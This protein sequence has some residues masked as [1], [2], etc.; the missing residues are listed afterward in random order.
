[1]L[2]GDILQFKSTKHRMINYNY[3]TEFAILENGK[4]LFLK[5]KKKSRCPLRQFFTTGI[6]F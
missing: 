6:I 1:M 5:K 4:L 2:R 3:K